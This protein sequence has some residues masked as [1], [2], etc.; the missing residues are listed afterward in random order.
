MH[1]KL[2]LFFLRSCCNVMEKL[3]YMRELDIPSTMRAV[4]S[5]LPFKLRERWRTV[6]HDILEASEHRAVFKDLVAFI[7]KTCP[8][9]I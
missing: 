6:A 8:N 1:Y 4:M 9:T 2:T 3:Q 5:K 7:E